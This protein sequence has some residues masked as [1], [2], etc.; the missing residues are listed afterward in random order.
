[1]AV[2]SQGL[3]DLVCGFAPDERTRIF[4]PRRR[5]RTEVLLECLDA[6]MGRT[7]EE[8]AGQFCEPTLHKVKRPRG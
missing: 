5:P 8:L 7:L 4:V 3:Q 2:S 1:L 6:A